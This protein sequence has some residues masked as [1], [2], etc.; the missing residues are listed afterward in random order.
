MAVHYILPKKGMKNLLII[1][2]LTFFTAIVSAQHISANNNVAIVTSYYECLFKTR[3]F[4]KLATL[5]APNATY[6]QAEGLPYGGTYVGV[7]NWM[8]MFIQAST[9]FDLQ[10]EQ[11]PEYFFKEK[12]DEIILRFTIRCTAKKSGNTLSMP[13]AEHFVVNAGKITAIRPF[14]FDTLKF[15]EFLK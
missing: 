7:E 1:I 9:Y 11:E 3:D 6:Y 8:K 15:S 2:T 5:I 13:I 4:T 10:I 14:Y 12:G